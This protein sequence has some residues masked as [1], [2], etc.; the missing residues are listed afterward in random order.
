MNKTWFVLLTAL[1][2]SLVLAGGQG[3]EHEASTWS[4]LMFP[5]F[6]AALFFSFLVYKLK[7]PVRNHFIEKAKSVSETFDRAQVK[8][9][10]AQVKYEALE[11]KLRNVSKEAEKIMSDSNAQA[12]E[13]ENKYMGEVNGRIEKSKQDSIQ[14]SLAEKNSLV[15][16]LNKKTAEAVV[17]KTKMLIGD[18]HQTKSLVTKKLLEGVR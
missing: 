15:N 6:N 5:A 16:Q 10:E 1:L 14:R 12:N 3:G 13:F 7:T 18:D 9:K 4:S 8:S 2:P 17:S 11:E